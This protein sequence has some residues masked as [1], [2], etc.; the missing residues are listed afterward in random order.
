M[1]KNYL[2]TLTCLLLLLTGCSAASETTTGSGDG[3]HEQIQ[4]GRIITIDAPEELT[5]SDNK[6]ALAADGLYYATWVTGSSIPY[7]NSEGET[8]DLYDAQLYFLAGES[9][10]SASAKENCVSWL[11]AAKENYDVQSETTITCNDQSYTL[12]TYQCISEDTPYDRG[13]SAFGTCG[14]IAVCAE[15]TCLEDYEGDLESTLIRLL[16]GCHYSTD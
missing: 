12:I 16:D 10:N 15:F 3:H 4:I 14:N 7:E 1:K 8:V 5:L 6:E 11:S 2:L 13:V 9:K